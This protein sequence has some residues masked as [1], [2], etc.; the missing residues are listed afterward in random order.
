MNRDTKYVSF[1][2]TRSL[3]DVVSGFGEEATISLSKLG[4]RVAVTKLAFI[5]QTL[6]VVVGCFKLP[7]PE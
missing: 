2:E 3:Q 5:S 4:H 6:H 1:Y 7:S